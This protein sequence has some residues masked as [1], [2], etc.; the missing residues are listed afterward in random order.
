MRLKECYVTAFGK[1]K[2]AKFVFDEP[3]TVINEDN[4]WGKSTLAAFIKCMF[5]GLSGDRK[6]SLEENERMRYKPWNSTEKFG[7]FVVFERAD[8]EYRL[9]RFFGNKE[10]EDS[11]RLYDN[12]SGVEYK[13]T[14]KLG[15][16]LFDLDEDGFF[17]TAF[18]SQKDFEVK[19]NSSITAKFNSL[20]ETSD[21]DVYDKAIEKLEKK[22]KEFAYSGNRGLIP[23]T[24]KKILET[25]ELISSA[26]ASDET[27]KKLNKE[28]ALIETEM[29]NAE[30]SA[31]KLSEE[32]SEAGRY[33][34]IELKNKQL[35]EKSKELDKLKQRLKECDVVLRG[36]RPNDK[37][38]DGLR[39]CVNEYNAVAL[40]VQSSENDLMLFERNNVAKKSVGIGLI[41]CLF[42]VSA[43]CF[44]AALLS[45][46]F[47]FAGA[48]FAIC[49]TALCVLRKRTK[50][51]NSRR[52]AT[53]NDKRKKLAEFN[54]ICSE[55]KSSI[56]VFLSEYGLGGSDYY[57][58]L[59]IISQ[60]AKDADRL[61]KDMAECEAYI[62]RL[63]EDDDLKLPIKYTTQEMSEIKKRY[64]DVQKEQNRLSAEYA[65]LKEAAAQQESRS[66]VLPDLIEKREALK[67]RLSEYN[68][69]HRTVTSA[70]KYLKV[71]DE[72]LKTKYREPLE[73]SLNKYLSY[74]D[75]NDVSAKIDIDLNVTVEE[76]SG[77]KD[78]EYYSAGYR[79]LFDICKRFALIDV[80]FTKEKPFI[81]LDD[82]FCNLD[83]KKI[84]AAIDLIKRLSEE[85]QIIYFVCHKSRTA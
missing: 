19:S 5:Y 38:I 30:T 41:G 66:E 76:K 45:V 78:A 72:T 61:E 26:Q 3:L 48:A 6:H 71:A 79:D 74:V 7:G 40:N 20:Y 15:R 81:I 32:L 17:S 10:A 34:S 42:G 60:N 47:I 22:S 62:S 33:E 54:D 24:K 84:A 70:L 13:N 39:V 9:E 68:E 50:D 58:A 77:K 11:V 43:V 53:L 1:L 51:Y 18:F 44:F 14:E 64:F 12:L 85:Y 56:D 75:G 36:K 46:W 63:K 57:R 83:A 8:R 31:Q 23:E 28:A 73:N 16:R 55:Y 27:A 59:S 21:A 82:P 65:R 49:A 35:E 80:L 4:G 67:E 37:D 69:K 52:D 29:K 25:E 2:D